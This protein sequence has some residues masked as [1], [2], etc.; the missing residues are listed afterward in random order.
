[1][2]IAYKRVGV[3]DSKIYEEIAILKGLEYDEDYKSAL[4]TLKGFVN[5]YLPMDELSYKKLTD[6]IKT[7]ITRGSGLFE[8]KNGICLCT[9]DPDE[10]LEALQEKVRRLCDG[11][12][13]SPFSY[14]F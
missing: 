6:S 9:N 4:L 11:T 2:Y 10:D 8:F 5:L 14:R 3:Y 7:A 12:S 13:Y 1:M